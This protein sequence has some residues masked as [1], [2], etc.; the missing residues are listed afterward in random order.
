MLKQLLTP[1]LLVIALFTSCKKDIRNQSSVL[2]NTNIDA[3]EISALGSSTGIIDTSSSWYGTYTGYNTPYPI[4]PDDAIIKNGIAQLPYLDRQFS[5]SNI[6]YDVPPQY[7]I[8][9]DSITFEAKLKNPRATGFGNYDV[10]LQLTG[11]QHSA[12][13][14][15]VADASYVQYTQYYV[16]KAKR[17][18][19]S[20]LVHYF[21]VFQTLKLAQKN[22]YTAVYINDS[23]VY[24]FKYGVKNSIGKLKT[25][26]IATKGYGT[27][28]MAALRNSFN[29][30][31]IFSEDFSID[32]KSNTV[33]Y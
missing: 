9:G 24:K 19:L 3:E 2:N 27:C 20:E 4:I 11:E 13:V 8:S 18:E 33:Y 26:N 17:T 22:Y 6:A 30:K 1:P 28:T 5:Y 21:G 25:I 29:R 10:V 12:E 15:F 7:N 16:G 31:P 14:H 23:L 32:G